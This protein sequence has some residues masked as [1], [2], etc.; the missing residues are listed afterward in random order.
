LAVN[1][2][3][4]TKLS[5][6]ERTALTTAATRT[7]TH[8]VT[9]TPQQEAKALS[10]LCTRGVVVVQPAD[11]ALSELRTAAGQAEPDGA[12]ATAWSTRL[13][14]A[15]AAA[16]R[17]ANSAAPAACPVATS[18]A[19]AEKLHGNTTSP[20]ATPSTKSSPAATASAFPT[21]TYVTKVTKEQWAAGNAGGSNAPFDVTFTSVMRP[22]GT[23]YQTQVPNP[24]DQGPFEGTYTV[25]GDR[26]VF[27]VHP[28]YNPAERFVE[29]VTW[30]YFKG[31]LHFV[32]VDVADTGSQVIYAQPWR[33][34]S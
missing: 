23:F 26:V 25:K 7:V 24:P 31:E 3:A 9:D 17:P 13:R 8:A 33:K 2:Q 12:Q 20:S 27:D 15:L 30:S 1:G 6:D 21:G 34:V 10:Q 18:A 14:D 22:D 4:W 5:D 11:Q 29:T 32:S 16:A 19:Q 28:V